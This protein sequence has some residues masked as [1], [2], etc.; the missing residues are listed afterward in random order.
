MKWRYTYM[1]EELSRLE[2]VEL[3][4]VWDTEAQHF[5]PWLAEEENLTL[6]GETLGMELELEAQEIKVGDFRADILCKN[7]DGTRVLIEN[8]LEE[9]DHSHLGQIL[10][11]AAGLDVH[12][13]IWIAKKFKDDHRAALDKLNEITD[14]QYRYFG[15]EIKVWQIRDSALAPQFHIIS[16]PNNWSRNTHN[17]VT[18]NL[19]EKEAQRYK[20]W[21]EFQNYMIKK[22]SQLQLPEPTT[23]HYFDIRIGTAYTPIRAWVYRNECIGVTLNLGHKKANMFFY[24]L[25]EQGDEIENQLGGQLEW[26]EKP[27]Q[28]DSRITLRK[29][30]TDSANE[31]DWQNQHEWLAT[32]VEQFYQIFKPRIDEFKKSDWEIP[33]D[34]DEE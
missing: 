18:K 5:T 29:G 9:T 16:S 32:K 4:E 21:T 28:N 6:L 25:K 22:G 3:R 1:S 33:E 13:V 19:S 23:R 15:I 11:Y 10:T 27:N 17:T 24:S 14:S 2:G 7:K 34:K 8:Q 12:T 31:T 30:N 26:E 20:Y